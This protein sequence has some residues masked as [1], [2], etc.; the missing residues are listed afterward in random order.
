MP[1][2]K[3]KNN[4]ISVPEVVLKTYD[5]VSKMSSCISKIEQWTRDHNLKHK[6]DI[7]PRLDSHSKRIRKIELIIAGIIVIPTVIVFLHRLG[8]LTFK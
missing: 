4:K 5:E 6:E 3:I 2:E 1:Q 8:I 7:K